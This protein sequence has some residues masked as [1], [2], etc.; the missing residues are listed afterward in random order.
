MNADD[1][2]AI[3][4]SLEPAQPRLIHAVPDMILGILEPADSRFARFKDDAIAYA[5]EVLRF[6]PFGVQCDILRQIAAPH[7]EDWHGKLAIGSSVSYGK[8]ACLGVIVN[9]F[10]DCRGPCLVPTTAPSQSSVVDLLW[11]EVRVL[12]SR[13]RSEWGI[14]AQ[15]FIGPAAPQMRRSAEWWAKGYVAAKGENFKGRHVERMCFLMDEAVGLQELYFRATKTMFQPGTIGQVGNHLW[16]AA[17]NPTDTA[18]VMYQE[19]IHP[20][21][22]WL[23]MEMSALEHPNVLAGLRGEPP[24]IPAAITLEQ[25]QGAIKGDCDRIDPA[26]ATALDFQWPAPRECPCCKGKGVVK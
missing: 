9:W 25:V 15:D 13:A 10:Y 8:T 1:L 4:A 16:I 3:A 21:S 7:S 20:E 22:D 19:I 18:S 24:P 23:V 11:K 26:E 17:Y 6:E 5:R 2:E 14:G 12:R